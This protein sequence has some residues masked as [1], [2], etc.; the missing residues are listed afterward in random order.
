MNH[1][2]L[3]TCCY[4]WSS[5]NFNKAKR[6]V[7]HIGFKDLMAAY[8]TYNFLPPISSDLDSLL[9]DFEQESDY[10][11]QTFGSVWQKHKL[12]FLFKYDIFASTFEII[13]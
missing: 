3:C 8:Y 4:Y 7:I 12:E 5:I 13:L 6:K 11:Y 10:D 9:H 1:I 2:Y